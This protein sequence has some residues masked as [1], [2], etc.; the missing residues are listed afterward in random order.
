MGTKLHVATDAD[1]KPKAKLAPRKAT[2]KR[3]KSVAAQLK[4]AMTPSRV[5]MAVVAA[6][7]LMV[8]LTD[9]SEGVDL[10]A[11]VPAW[12]GWCMAIVFDLFIVADEYLLLTAEM[13]KD[14]RYAAE[15][16]MGIVIMWS[17]YLNAV[18]FSHNHFDIEHITQ[19]AMG[20]SLPLCIALAAYAAARCK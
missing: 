12:K 4:K 18:A 3:A 19:I 2:S 11:G 13:E 17:M 14:A 9:L 15:A 20:I 6:I 10:L 16:L 1:V 8:S 7:A 5:F